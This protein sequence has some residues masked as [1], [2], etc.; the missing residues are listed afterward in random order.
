MENE[1]LLAVEETK[2]EDITI[3]EI[4]YATDIERGLAEDSI[5]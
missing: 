2:S 1:S 4:Q 3:D 5:A